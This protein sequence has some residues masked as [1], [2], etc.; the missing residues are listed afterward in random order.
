MVDVFM[1]ETGL[2]EGDIV[3]I[4][5]PIA[6][7]WLEQTGTVSGMSFS[8]AHSPHPRPKSTSP[9]ITTTLP[10]TNIKRDS[11]PNSGQ[12]IEMPVPKILSQNFFGILQNES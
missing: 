1:R 10:I 7:D 8:P 3:D 2:E 12:S 4:S 6:I 5:N 9:P 11:S